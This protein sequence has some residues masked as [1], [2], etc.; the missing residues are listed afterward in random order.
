MGAPFHQIEED[1]DFGNVRMEN[2]VKYLESIQSVMSSNLP[3]GADLHRQ[4]CAVCHGDD[5]R[6]GGSV[7]PPYT[8]PPDLTTLA[9]GHAG[10]FPRSYVSEVLRNGIAAHGPAEMPIW[11]ADFRLGDQLDEVAIK[12][13]IAALTSYLESHQEK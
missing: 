13:R 8:V 5:L 1:Q 6:G 12:S 4:D 11:G 2:I 7:P 3:S 9:W 10:K